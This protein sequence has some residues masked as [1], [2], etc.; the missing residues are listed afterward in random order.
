[1]FSELQID[2]EKLKYEIRKKSILSSMPLERVN[3]SDSINE[4]NTPPKNQHQELVRSCTEIQQGSPLIHPTYPLEKAI[5]KAPQLLDVL[6]NEPNGT[7]PLRRS[8]DN[9]MIESILED[10]HNFHNEIEHNHVLALIKAHLNARLRLQSILKGLPCPPLTNPI[11]MSQ[12]YIEYFEKRQLPKVDSTPILHLE[13]YLAHKE[14]NPSTTAEIIPEL[15][16]QIECDPIS[17]HEMN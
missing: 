9:D 12:D 14:K 8:K 16:S 3:P 6:T 2:I 4:S 7:N 11:I 13:W 17:L 1:M 15:E 5:E 10:K